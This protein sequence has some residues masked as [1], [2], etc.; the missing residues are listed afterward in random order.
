MKVLGGKVITLDNGYIPTA[1]EEK[2]IAALADPN[3]FGKS[4][5]AK[6]KAA[7]ISRTVF[8][9]SVKKP[10]FMELYNS[11]MMDMVRASVG[12]ILAASIKYAASEKGAYQDRKMLLEMAG[13]YTPKQVQELQGA[14]GEPLQVTFAIARPDRGAVAEISAGQVPAAE[15]G[16]AREDYGDYIDVGPEAESAPGRDFGTDPE[17]T[18]D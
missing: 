2:L 3:N 11:M 18:T 5:T 8:Y 4:V 10:G 6:C 7:G 13:I 9:D 12:D 1:G 15:I 16:P 17:K 14:G